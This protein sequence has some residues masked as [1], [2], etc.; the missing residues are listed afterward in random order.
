MVL[1]R[2]SP[3]SIPFYLLSSRKVAGQIAAY[4]TWVFSAQYCTHIFLILDL[5]VLSR[6]FI[7]TVAAQ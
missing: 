6:L 1:L 4:A 3:L 2:H 7:G 5:K